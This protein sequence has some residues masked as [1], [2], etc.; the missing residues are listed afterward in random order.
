MI[1]HSLYQLLLFQ[2]TEDTLC[3]QLSYSFMMHD[4]AADGDLQ[5]IKDAIKNDGYNSLDI[6]KNEIN[7]LY[8]AAMGGHLSVMKFILDDLNYDLT[9]P[10]EK[11]FNILHIAATFG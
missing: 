5:A 10:M 6:D 11:K 7:S 4:M 9:I 1:S 2:K 3:Q 8:W